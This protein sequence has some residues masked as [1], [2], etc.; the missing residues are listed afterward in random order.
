MGGME[1]ADQCVEWQGYEKGN[2][3]YLRLLGCAL[4]RPSA[5]VAICMRMAAVSL[6]AASAFLRGPGRPCFGLPTW[7]R[8][9]MP[10][11]TQALEYLTASIQ[12]SHLST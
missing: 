11:Y 6:S 5:T 3:L 10:A 8:S 12:I 2:R 9:S 4:P 1:I 7:L